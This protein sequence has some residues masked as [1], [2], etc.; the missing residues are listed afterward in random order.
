MKKFSSK[1]EILILGALILLLF[2][3]N[4]F[5]DK[6]KD[7]FYSL[8]EPLQIVFLEAGKKTAD[9]FVFFARIKDL[10]KDNESLF[11]ENQSLRS[12]IVF[13]KELEK[14]NKAL[15]NALE[16]NLQEDFQLLLS[17]FVS[18]D[19]L[20]DSIL[21]DKGEKDGV[22]EGAAVLTPQKALLG[23]IEK[24]YNNFSVVTLITNKN[25]SFPC[26]IQTDNDNGVVGIIKG[27][28][29]VELFFDLIP[30]DA[31]IKPGQRVATVSLDGAFPKGIFVGE[32]E[33]LEKSDLQSYQK[34]RI[35]PA[36]DLGKLETLFVILNY[37]LGD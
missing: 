10:E 5:Q 16:L 15:R 3:L 28:G 20:S 37:K 33:E 27:L 30:Q 32:I 22:L 14:E 26:K 12:Q 36:F 8:S 1:K 23:K 17:Y 24:V 9:F 2:F 29:G 13:L 7:F 11:A 4:A 34:A 19:A 31:E 6:T 25:F 21:I 18:K 35:K